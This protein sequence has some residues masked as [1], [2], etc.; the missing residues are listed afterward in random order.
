MDA[1][2]WELLPLL[3]G[4]IV[5]IAIGS[6]LVLILLSWME[7]LTDRPRPMATPRGERKPLTRDE[8]YEE[9]ARRGY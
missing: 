4:I 3:V 2:R 5:G 9:A 6:A 1:L 7:R 8:Q